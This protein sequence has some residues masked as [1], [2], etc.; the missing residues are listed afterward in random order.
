MKGKETYAVLIICA[1]VWSG[2]IKLKGTK[3]C[4]F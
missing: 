3:V 1:T 4:H 2:W